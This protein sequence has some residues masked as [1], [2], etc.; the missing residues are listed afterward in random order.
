MKFSNYQTQGFYDELFDEN[1]TPRP[2][3]DLIRDI[4]GRFYVLEDNMRCVLR[5]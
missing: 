4:D 5:P 1:N 3:T 2:G